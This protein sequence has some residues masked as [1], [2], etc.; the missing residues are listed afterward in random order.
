MSFLKKVFYIFFPKVEI[1]SDFSEKELEILRKVGFR[2]FT[3]D[4]LIL[5]NKDKL[6]MHKLEKQTKMESVL[7]T[8]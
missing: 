5:M 2:T 8:N 4:E 1:A 7:A 3:Q 6:E